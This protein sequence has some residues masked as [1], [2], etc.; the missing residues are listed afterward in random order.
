M[1]AATLESKFPLLAVENG[2]IVSKD[3]DITAGFRVELPELFTVTSSE[4]EA[5]HSAWA[6]AIKVLPNFSIV[7]K[8]DWFIKENYQ[9]D[10]Q[11]DDLSFL[12]RS[13]ERHF[14]E[15]PYLNHACFLFLTKTTKERMRAQSN[16]NT[17]CRGFLVPKEVRDKE[18]VT[19][20]LEAVG[21]FERIVND[22]GFVKLTKLT[23]DEIIG[24]CE[25]NGTQGTAGLI[26]KYF[27]LS[28]E[29]TTCLEDIALGADEMRIG[30]NILCLHTLSDTEDLPSKVATDNRYEKLST[31]RSDCRLSFA[32]SVG[33]LLSCNHIYN[34]YLF[35]DDSA[36]NLKR[37]EKQARNMHSLSR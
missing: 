8:A 25:T 19:K 35:I 1:K 18:A 11:K 17:L 16:F 33:V 27:S 10:I 26:E 21:Q 34:Q 20:F 3:A 9:P 23:S 4:Y 30:D 15:R 28:L 24:T 7:H 36:E 37:F 14:N 5:I 22:S 12:S 2:C 6:K 32:A 31:D 29:N 13:F